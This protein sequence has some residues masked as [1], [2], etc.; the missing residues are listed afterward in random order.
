MAFAHGTDGAGL[1]QFDHAAV[2]I[3]RVNLCAHLSGEFFVCC[4]EASNRAR[5]EYRVGKGLFTI[6]MFSQ[7][8]GGARCDRVSVVRR[9]DDNGINVLLLQHLAKV[10]IRFRLGEFRFCCREQALVNVAKGDD[11]LP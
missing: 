8:Q 7:P 2:V 1:N 6:D 4:R 9:A 10:G 5:L 11:V 3:T